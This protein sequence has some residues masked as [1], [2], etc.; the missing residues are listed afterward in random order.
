M[1]FSFKQYNTW[2]WAISILQGRETTEEIS[3]GGQEDEVTNN[4]GQLTPLG[5]SVC[6]LS[7]TYPKPTLQAF[8]MNKFKKVNCY[9]KFNTLKLFKTEFSE[10]YT[11]EY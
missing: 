8:K 7:K 11:M 3:G 5:L 6:S 1:Y 9:K 4:F 2:L 10:E